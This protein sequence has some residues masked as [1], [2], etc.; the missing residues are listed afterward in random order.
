MT[1]VIGVVI[2]DREPASPIARAFMALAAP[3]DRETVPGG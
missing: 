3:L 2:A 1:H